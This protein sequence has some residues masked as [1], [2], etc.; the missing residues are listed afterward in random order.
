MV[1][2][3]PIYLD[4]QATTP[5]DERVKEAMLPYLGATFGNPHSSTHRYGWEAEAALDIAREN[6]AAVVGAKDKEIFFTSGA[7]ETNNLAIKGVMD[8]WGEKRPKLVTV[9]T[10]HKCVL[11][12]ALYCAQR[13]Y[14]LEVLPVQPN[15]LLDLNRVNEA[16]DD[17]TA[18]ISV[19]AV[20]NEIGVIQPLK[21]IGEMAK[22]VG[23]LFHM[24]A[25][26]AF[27]KIALDVD[28]L[29]ID[30][31]SISGHK[32]Y[33]PKGVGALYKRDIRQTYLTPQMSGGGQEGGVRSGTQAPALVAGLGKAAELASTDM[34][35]EEGRLASMMLR[36]KTKLFGALPGLRLNGDSEQRWAGNLNISF[37]G[38]DGDLLISSIRELAVSSGA[39]CASAIEGHSYVLEAI[40]LS[41]EEA[42]SSL[43]IG[44][45]RFSTD[46]ELDYAAD[47]L[48]E[49]VHKLGGMK[50]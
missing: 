42:G 37:T 5:V 24:D 32:I 21:E 1:I 3:K 29:N 19:M 15:G 30:F 25:A 10:E 28:D 38:I 11:E 23:A 7:T 43:R 44:V 49:A 45:G 26:Q 34:Q 13:G 40:G 12:A 6:V 22:A 47:Y 16:L 36:F 17:K 31:M 33:G 48:I 20:N 35:Q 14:E 18:L 27:G 39:A 9:A 2:K 8:V 41:K 46:E 4:Y 50:A